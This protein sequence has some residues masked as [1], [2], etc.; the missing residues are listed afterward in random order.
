MITSLERRS[1]RPSWLT[2]F[3]GERFFDRI[4]PE[5]RREM[6]EEW[7]PAINFSEKN[8]KYYVTADIPGVKKEDI[9]VTLEN[10]YLTVSGKKE[11][12]KEEKEANYYM[13]ETHYGSFSRSFRLPEEVDESKIEATYKDGVLTVSVEK[14]EKSV[15]KK[16]AIH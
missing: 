10:G 16:I 15:T 7:S 8:G 12:S 13:K 6:G 3:G 5:W 4:W 1:R 9:S 14:S 2:P 11:E